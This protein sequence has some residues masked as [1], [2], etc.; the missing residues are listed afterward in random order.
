MVIEAFA[1]RT[2]KDISHF[3]PPTEAVG[4]PTLRRAIEELT[5]MPLLWIAA[6]RLAMNEMV[7]IPSES[8][9][10]VAMNGYNFGMVKATMLAKGRDFRE[11]P[12]II[13]SSEVTDR[14]IDYSILAK[15]HGLPEDEMRRI[16]S[17][18]YDVTPIGLIVPVYKDALPEHLLTPN[19][20]LDEEIPTALLVWNRRY[21]PWR[22]FTSYT[23]RYPH[24]LDVGTSHNLHGQRALN[25]GE[26]EEVFGRVHSVRDP[27]IDR[28]P[29][30]G[31]YP[32]YDAIRNI[33]SRW[34]YLLLN[35]D[36][37]IVDNLRE[38]LGEKLGGSLVLP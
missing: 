1:Q 31:S 32:H 23:A 13:E 8:V 5:M 37:K 36:Q 24:V 33:V 20:D 26:S 30:K 12:G 4:R 2:K 34:G 10:S 29:R 15:I 16:V 6:K 25:V 14:F 19:S 18:V 3:Q 22:W 21:R 38:A 27:L 17:A 7:V 28:H 11:K 35:Q 9:Y